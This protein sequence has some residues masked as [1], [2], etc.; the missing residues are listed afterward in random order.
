MFLWANLHKKRSYGAA[1]KVEDAEI[2]EHRITA[3]IE[4]ITP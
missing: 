3:G 1:A 2:L 4:I